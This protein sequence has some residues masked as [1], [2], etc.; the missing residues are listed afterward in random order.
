MVGLD[1]IA[2]RIQY[3][4]PDVFFP[5]CTQLAADINSCNQCVLIG[6]V[7]GTLQLPVGQVITIRIEYFRCGALH[8]PVRQVGLGSYL[9]PSL[10]PG[11]C[12]G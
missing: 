11:Q 4:Y 2:R 6:Q 5:A 7:P 3:I 12:I 9:A 8:V 10:L 1:N